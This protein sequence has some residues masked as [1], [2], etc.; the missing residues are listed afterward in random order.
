MTRYIGDADAIQII[1]CSA[2]SDGVGDVARAG[3]EAPRRRLIEGLLEGYILN[4]VSAALPGRHVVQ[5]LGLSIDN[6]DAGRSKDL[7][8]SADIGGAIYRLRVNANARDG[9]RTLQQHASAV[10]MSGLNHFLHRQNRAQCIGD[11]GDRNQP[12]LWPRRI[13]CWMGVRLTGFP[14]DGIVRLISPLV[15]GLWGFENI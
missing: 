8:S 2:Q 1:N 14:I 15:A 3:F 11:M 9:L 6:A 7:V 10:P 4:Q 13:L 5:H 12:S